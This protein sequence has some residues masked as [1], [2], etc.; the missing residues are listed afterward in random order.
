MLIRFIR[1]LPGH[2]AGLIVFFLAYTRCNS[3]WPYIGA[4]AFGVAV[5]ALVERGLLRRSPPQVD[6]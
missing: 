2:L 5:W 1:Y 6:D 3:I 4:L